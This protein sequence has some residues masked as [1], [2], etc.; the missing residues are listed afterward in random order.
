SSTLGG[1]RR[2]DKER[3]NA[4]MQYLAERF[5][6]FDGGAALANV[7]PALLPQVVPRVCNVSD[8]QTVVGAASVGQEFDAGPWTAAKVEAATALVAASSRAQVL[9]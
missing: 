9:A 8:R 7:F 1:W 5:A 4:C 6:G 3:A 2:E